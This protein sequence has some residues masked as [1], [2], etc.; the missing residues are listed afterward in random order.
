MN[1]TK[2]INDRDRFNI[3]R[4]YYD[5]KGYHSNGS[6]AVSLAK[7]FDQLGFNSSEDF[8]QWY[9]FV[10]N[11]EE[12]KSEWQCSGNCCHSILKQLLK[13]RKLIGQ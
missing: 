10:P 13:M 9:D 2:K 7:L 3:L 12:L 1:N 11:K 5:K 6:K 4:G 8:W